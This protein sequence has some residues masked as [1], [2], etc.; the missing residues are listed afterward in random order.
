[1]TPARR[2]VSERE[3]RPEPTRQI[4]FA[5]QLGRWV[6]ERFFACIERNQRQGF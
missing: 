2:R 6:F 3:L 5:A 4:G 1:V